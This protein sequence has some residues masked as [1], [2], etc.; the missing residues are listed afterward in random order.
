MGESMNYEKELLSITDDYRDLLPDQNITSIIELATHNE[1]GEA[2][3][4]LCTQLFEY[5]IKVSLKNYAILE[6]MIK[7]IG[8]DMNLV[9]D[10]VRE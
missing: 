8:L 3:E 1:W 7:E 10:L 6:E 4:V 9:A 5:D 2:I